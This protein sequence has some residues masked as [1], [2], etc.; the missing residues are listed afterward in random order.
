[1]QTGSPFDE[2]EELSILL[3]AGKTK[4]AT[5]IT[6]GEKKKFPL[7]EAIQLPAKATLDFLQG[8]GNKQQKL[9]KLSVTPEQVELSIVSLGKSSLQV[10]LPPEA[11]HT[12]AIFYN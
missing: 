3:I 8:Q 12:L 11:S 5:S 9:S 2:I 1:M 4:I 7:K 10:V 6:Y